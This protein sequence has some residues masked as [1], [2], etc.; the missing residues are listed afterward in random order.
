MSSKKKRK[1]AKDHYLKQ[2][3][4]E[5]LLFATPKVDSQGLFQKAKYIAGTD[6]I[7]M[8]G[9]NH[10]E[11]IVF[12]MGTDGNYI[13]KKCN[14]N[15]LT[16]EKTVIERFLHR[17]AEHNGGP[18]KLFYFDEVSPPG[19]KNDVKQVLDLLRN[20]KEEKP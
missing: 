12:N 5:K 14:S 11:M 8:E 19:V 9:D 1:K 17:I 20:N 4:I 13:P 3:S 10:S 16:P 7:P 6:P 15:I 18:R 2:P